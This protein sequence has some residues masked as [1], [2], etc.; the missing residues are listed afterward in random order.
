MGCLP[1][2]TLKAWINTARFG[3]VNFGK[4]II[5][6]IL[7]KY[8]ISEMSGYGDRFLLL[9]PIMHHNASMTAYQKSK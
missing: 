6:K 4:L 2:L 9:L 3:K 1:K 8:V 5:L 7:W